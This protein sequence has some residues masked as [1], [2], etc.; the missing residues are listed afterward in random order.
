MANFST[1]L[2]GETLLVRVRFAPSPTGA[3]H[4]G[5]ARTA[6]FNYLFAR[7]HGGTFVLRIEDTDSRRRV[8][9][10]IDAFEEAFAWLGFT[11][12]EGPRKGGPYGPY[13]QSQRLARH[14]SQADRLLATGRAYRCFCSRERLAELRASQQAAGQVP[15]YDRHCASLD[16]AEAEARAQSGAPYVVRLRIP[17]TG[18]V[19]VHD[20]IRGDV[21]F[22][23][24]ALDDFVILKS[25]GTPTYNFAVVVDDSDMAITHVLRGEE[26]LSNTPKQLHVYAAL[27]LKPPFFAHIPMILAADRSKLSKR[28]GATPLRQFIEEGYLPEAVVN[29]LMLLGWSPGGDEEILSLEEACRRFALEQVQKSAAIYDTQKLRWMNGVY[30]RMLPLDVIE[31]RALPFLREKGVLPEE[32]LPPGYVRE[33]IRLVRERVSTLT[34]VAEAVIYFFRPI[35]AYDEKGVDKYF[36][37]LSTARRLNLLADR[38]EEL[39]GW[40]VAALEALYTALSEELG[41]KRAELIHPTRLAVT[42]RTMGPGLFEILALLGKQR[43]VERLRAAVRYV[44]ERHGAPEGA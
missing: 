12:D 7:R 3:P 42:G 39:D 40:D 9:E 41:V 23:N 31:A 35:E 2:W 25:D 18:T 15:H 16:P 26:H 36:R 32:A 11:Y 33:A 43:V 21:T 30:L 20:L 13:I 22:D 44:E 24:A 28:H 29:Y 38:L 10:A 14:R 17:E 19:V 27:G 4:I 37:D 1:K 5:W 6:L 34:E 8:D